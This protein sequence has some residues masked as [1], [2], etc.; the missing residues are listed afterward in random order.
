[1]NSVRET[2]LVTGASG[3]IGAWTVLTLIRQGAEVVALDRTPDDHRLRLIASRDELGKIVS[4]QGDIT[5]LAG[6]E[7]V[8]VEREV[9]HVVHLAALQA[10][11][12]RADPPLGAR[13][14]VLGTTNVLEAAK[15][16]GLRTPVVYASSA[17]VY[18]ATAGTFTPTTIYGVYKVANEGCA[19]IYWEEEQVASVGLRPNVVYG[20]GRDQGMTAS[21][22]EAVE[23]A[24]KGEPFHIPFGGSMQLQYAPDVAR[25]FIDGARRP[26]MGAEV[27]NLGGPVISVPEIISAITAVVPE[28]QITFEETPLP[29]PSRL[30]EPWFGMRVTPLEQGIAESVEVFG[31]PP[32]PSAG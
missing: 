19:R 27:F 32:V 16:H 11:F 6:L 30:P 15:R 26:R 17:A 12:C 31:R 8:L 25:A 20:P 24:V 4:V 3:C 22:S 29:F 7:R 5:D 2:W 1:M 10:P 23:A 9:T 14:N 13:V 21:P 18:D 28:A